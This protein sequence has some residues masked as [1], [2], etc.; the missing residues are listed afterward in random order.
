[1]VYVKKWIWL[2]Y[3]CFLNEYINLVQILIIFIHFSI[4][5]KQM[6]LVKTDFAK[7]LN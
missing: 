5:I 2:S 7:D 3:T 1:M 6:N 4:I